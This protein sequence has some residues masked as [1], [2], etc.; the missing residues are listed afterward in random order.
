MTSTELKYTLGSAL[1]VILLIA[2]YGLRVVVKGRVH[3]DRLER[4]GGS[5]LL[6]TG[7]MHIGYW[8][9]Y[10]VAQLFASLG[11][12]PNTISWTSLG[13]GFLAGACLAAGHFGYGA[14][15][16]TI[17]GLLDSL[18]GMVARISGAASNAGEVLDAAVD[19]YVEFFFLSGLVIYYRGIPGL[20]ILALLALL[21]SF[22][23][24]YSTTKAE[25]LGVEPPRGSMRRPERAVYLTLGAA[26]SA[27][28]VFWWASDTPMVLA[29]GLVAVAAN[30]SAVRRL[31][32]VAKAVRVRDQEASLRRAEPNTAEVQ[33]DPQ[34]DYRPVGRYPGAPIV[35]ALPKP[36]LLVS[37]RRAQIASLTATVVDFASL[38]FLVEVGHVWYVAATATG[39]L[40]G[41]IVNFMLGRH[42]TFMAN[43]ESVRRQVIRYA[44]VAAMS[45][46]LNSIGVYLL[47]EYL[48]IYYAM[49][50]VITAFLVG[51]LF[52]FP[53]QRLFVFK[54]HTYA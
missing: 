22:M 48:R 26:L 21:G 46:V 28:T 40:L 52:N 16:A 35:R 13:S 12:T 30:V 18:D 20:Q 42:W 34:I 5:R 54:R 1:I 11:I 49:S 15:F 41:A 44:G 45:L 3:F 9:L 23:V 25:A 38:I 10:P 19:R 24:S 27:L 29:L 2:G 17:S 50:K 6:S 32:F 33:Q 4:Q 14:I 47:T 36:S 53:L 8:V 31:W 43:R 7:A 37:L 51:L 39:A